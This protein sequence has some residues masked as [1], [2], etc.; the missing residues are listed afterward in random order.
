MRVKWKYMGKMEMKQ[1][2]AGHKRNKKCLNKLQKESK[3]A[4]KGYSP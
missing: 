4:K 3:K 1:Y 2:E